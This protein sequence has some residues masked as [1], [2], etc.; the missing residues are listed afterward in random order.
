MLSQALSRNMRRLAV[1]RAVWGRY[2]TPSCLART[3]HEDQAAVLSGDVPFDR[4]TA[5]TN[6]KAMDGMVSSLRGL[7]AKV[8]MGGPHTSREKHTARGKLLARERINALVDSCSPFLE[9][10]QLAG[11]ELYGKEDVPAGGVI[12]GVGTIKER[13]CMIVANDATVAGGSWFV[14]CLLLTVYVDNIFTG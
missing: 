11:H 12:T 6:Q 2:N 7:V 13:Q 9:L 14:Y 10:S 4:E 1:S 3:Y 5:A 8:K